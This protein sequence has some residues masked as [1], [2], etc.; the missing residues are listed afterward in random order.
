MCRLG[1]TFRW[2]GEN[3]ST[4]E[5]GEVLGNFP[6]VVEANVYGVQLPNHDGRAGAAAIYIEP[7]KK[8]SFDTA[9]FLAHARTH[10]P[11]Y[12][13]PIFLRHIAVISASHNNK[14][15][16]QP[17]KAEGVDPDKVKAGDEIWWIEDG[18]KGNR[19][20]PFTREDWNALGVG[21]AKL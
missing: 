7:E 8:A 21:K 19:Y 5:V 17:L 6:G 4:A 3:V 2:K 12:A 1:D 14:Q 15:N 10:L 11:K 20:V 9:A 18:G 16:K 13:V